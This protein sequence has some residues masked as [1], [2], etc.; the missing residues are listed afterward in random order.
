MNR[1][2]G[3]SVIKATTISLVFL[4][5]LQL[6]A[7]NSSSM[8]LPAGSPSTPAA[9]EPATNSTTGAAPKVHKYDQVHPYNPEFQTVDKAIKNKEF[10]E[11]YKVTDIRLRAAAGSLSK[12]SINSNFAITGPR[13][14]NLQDPTV[15]NPD[16]KVQHGAQ[17]LRGTVSGRYRLDSDHAVGFGAGIQFDHPIQGID[18]TNASTPFLS[19]NIANRIGATQVISSPGVSYTTLPEYT[20]VGQFAAAN[21]MNSFVRNLGSS[22][23]AL[24]LDINGSYFMYN[25]GYVQGAGGS[26]AAYSQRGAKQRDSSGSAASN[27]MYGGDNYKATQFSVSTGPGLKYNF[28][29]HMNV[30]T[31]IEVNYY[32]PR[33][34]PNPS[35]IWNSTPSTRL[36]LGYAYSRA[37]YIAPYIQTYPSIMTADMTTIN[38]STI[39]SLL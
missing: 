4:G 1:F 27:T 15:P 22:R 31:S 8:S 28:S 30:Y 19:Y 10:Q 6:H 24:S 20:A 18:K 16:G 13:V 21:V 25:R 39:F 12:Y 11:D 35:V 38:I 34:Q 26:G 14:G 36:G 33:S 5:A 3:G 17:T 23:F 2:G 37:I 32:N 29:D 7:Q 9:I